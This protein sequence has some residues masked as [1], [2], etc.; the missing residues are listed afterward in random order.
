MLYTDA[1]IA[2]T[3]T[4]G[5]SEFVCSDNR[6]KMSWRYARGRGW[7]YGKREECLRGEE[8]RTWMWNSR[9]PG[10]DFKASSSVSRR[11]ILLGCMR[12]QLLVAQVFVVLGLDGSQSRRTYKEQALNPNSDGMHSRFDGSHDIE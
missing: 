1:S 3:N 8:T 12:L 10:S 9:V 2:E 11:F 5:E 7:A 4:R 6:M